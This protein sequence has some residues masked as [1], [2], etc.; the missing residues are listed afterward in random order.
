MYTD[1]GSFMKTKLLNNIM[2][3]VPFPVLLISFFL[4][5]S[6]QTV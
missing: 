4:A 5:H 1:G 2:Y 6:N 3:L